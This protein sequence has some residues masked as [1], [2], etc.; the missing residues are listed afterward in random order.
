MDSQT[1]TNEKICPLEELGLYLDGELSPR[2]EILL[3]KH[4]AAC[5]SCLTELNLQKQM[6]SALNFAFDRREEIE[7]PK[8]FTK[9][10]VTKAESG[11]SGLRSKEE[12]FRALFLCSALFLLLLLGLGAESEKILA[13][14][15]GFLSQLVVI[16]GF[17]V[18][19]TYDISLG[20][21]VILRSISQKIVVS[22]AFF[23]LIIG[24]LLSL[25]LLTLPRFVDKLSRAKAS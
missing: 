2:E 17:I 16:A 23:V 22:S 4:L 24:S 5:E 3:E 6:L 9:I 13:A 10:V 7:L 8:D 15:S 11:V 14:V 18:H 25:F 12:R 1:V 21:A 20:I 19:L